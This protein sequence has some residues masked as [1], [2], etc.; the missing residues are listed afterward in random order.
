MIINYSNYEV[1]VNNELPSIFLAGP[2]P[3]EKG[4]LSWRKSAID[5]LNQL[6]YHGIVYVPEYDNGLIKASYVDQVEWERKAMQNSSCILFWLDRDLNKLPGYT[7][8]VEFGYWIAKKTNIIV[9]GRPNNSPKTKYLDWLYRI[10]KNFAPVD[11]LKD[12]IKQSVEVS[13]QNVK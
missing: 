10:E 3:R 13:V 1:V 9:Y 4:I 5:I 12:L 7:T 6:E 2:T 11:N 8:N